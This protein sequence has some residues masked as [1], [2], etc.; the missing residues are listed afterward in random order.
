VGRK[1]D[2][3]G[4]V[5]SPASSTSDF[6]PTRASSAVGAFFCVGVGL[7]VLYARTGIGMP[8]PFR[9]A[10]GWDCP[11][12]GGTRMGRALLDVDVA[13]AFAF[14]PLA[15]VAVGMLGGLGVLWLLE[16]LGGPRVR[17][18]ATLRRG[19]L[20]V[21]PSQWLMLGVVA[22]VGYTVARNLS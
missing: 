17:P 21:Q 10:T 19:L 18:P 13:A 20:R 3:N 4:G 9:L 6:S 22:G 11:L 8:C 2:Q 1:K 5:G 15:L 7:S 16:A 12:C 14:N